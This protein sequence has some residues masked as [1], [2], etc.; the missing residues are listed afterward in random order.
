MPK[1][2]WYLSKTDPARTIL[3]VICMATLVIELATL[4]PWIT[5]WP[6]V[7]FQAVNVAVVTIPAI[8]GLVAGIKND[9]K[10]MSNASFWMFLIWLW[11][12]VTRI[13][14]STEPLALLWTPFLIVALVLAVIYIYM[15]HLNKVRKA[16]EEDVK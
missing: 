3:L 2:L 16:L 4:T 5:P 11:S 9:V 13:F 6:A 7:L 10:W 15:S 12:G 1:R 14:V 8:V